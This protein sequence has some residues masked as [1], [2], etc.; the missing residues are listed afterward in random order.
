MGEDEVQAKEVEMLTY[1]KETLPFT[2]Q[3]EAIPKIKYKT[4]QFDP[5]PER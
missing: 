5:G 2:I 3:G 4:K 1:K